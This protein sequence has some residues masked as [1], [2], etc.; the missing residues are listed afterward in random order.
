MQVSPLN[1]AAAPRHT[2]SADLAA[3]KRGNLKPAEQRA[4]VASQFE[5]IIV[6]QL[7]QESV[8]SMMGGK[9]G[10]ASGN[11]YGYMLT[12]T[13]AQKI[14]EGGGMGLAPMIAQQLQPRGHLLEEGETPE[15]TQP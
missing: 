5:A 13:F 12:D 7:L 4:A 8:G 2:A 9:E 11:V 15:S 1:P 6:R 10:G 14:T 3:L